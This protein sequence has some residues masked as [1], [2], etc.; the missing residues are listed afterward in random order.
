ML[1]NI[2]AV[3]VVFLAFCP[4]QFAQQAAGGAAQEF[5]NDSVIKLIKAGLSDELIVSTINALAGAY[6]TSPDGLVALK[7]AHASDK[8]RIGYCAEGVILRTRCQGSRCRARVDLISRRPGWPRVSAKVIHSRS[9]RDHRRRRRGG[10]PSSSRQCAASVPSVGQQG[11]KSE[12]SSG[13][14]DGDEQRHGKRLPRR[15]GND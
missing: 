7:A 12:R 15:T 2:R 8:S 3:A 10:D 4:L 9:D 1:H 13:P 14:V 6:D 5:N 11:D